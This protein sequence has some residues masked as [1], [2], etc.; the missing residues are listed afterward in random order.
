MSIVEIENA[1]KNLPPEKV[2]ELMDWFVKYHAE[3]WD[4]EIAKDLDTGRFDSI[5]AEVESDISSGVAKPL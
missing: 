3:I 2:N 4:D 1:I 5:L